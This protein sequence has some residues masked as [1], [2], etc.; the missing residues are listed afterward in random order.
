MHIIATV[1]AFLGSIISATATTASFFGIFD[2]PE[3]P[4]SLRK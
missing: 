2:E 1:T 3:M 4:E